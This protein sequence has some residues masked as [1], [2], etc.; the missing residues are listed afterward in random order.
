MIHKLQD[1][2]STRWG[3]LYQF[4]VELNFFFSE[5]T[6]H[7]SASCGSDWQLRLTVRQMVT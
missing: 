4:D 2:G 6:H 1:K 3:I 7:Y 5:I